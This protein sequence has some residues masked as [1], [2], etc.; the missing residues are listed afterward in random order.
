MRMTSSSSGPAEKFTTVRRGYAPDEVGAYISRLAG[1]LDSARQDRESAARRV[2]ELAAG[3]DAA[4]AELAAARAEL[5]AAHADA[6]ALREELDRAAGQPI[7]M[8]GLSSRMQRLFQIAEEESADIR[9]SADRY[10]ADVRSQADSE[11]A[12]RRR[13][14]EA[15]TSKLR[16]DTVAELTK[17]RRDTEAEMARAQDEIE[18]NRA[19]LEQTRTTVYEQAKRL[20]AEAHSSAEVTLAEARERAEHLSTTAAA[21]RAKQE[22]D[23]ELA[24][25]ARR[26]QAHRAIVEAEQTARADAAHRVDQANTHA[27]NIVESANA[28]A[29]DMLRRAASESHQRV[30][31]ADEAV[32]KL[33]ALRSEL[34]QQILDL[35]GRLGDLSDT[36]TTVRKT[37][38]PLAL[39]NQRPNPDSFPAEPPAIGSASSGVFTSTIPQWH[40]P[41]P[42]VSLSW[43][44]VSAQL[45]TAEPN[46]EPAPEPPDAEPEN[47]EPKNAESESAPEAE[48][49]VPGAASGAE[50]QPD[51]AEKPAP[52]KTASPAARARSDR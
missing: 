31:E 36:M 5:A 16:S 10:A 45:E 47:A 44:K 40:P 37:L 25:E 14:A 51:H 20:M 6:D 43:E 52:K 3:L 15:E 17:L 30:A 28:H 13:T 23:Y 35:S 42:P 29:E 50:T 4:K 21:D 38:E 39:E 27:R 12:E 22:E 2:D 19:E 41:T 8:S 24:I 49:A 26:R 7:S 9:S 46:A 18:A 11:A 33:V 34:Q 48:D 32:R 1:S